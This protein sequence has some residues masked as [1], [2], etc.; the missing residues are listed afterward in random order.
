MVMTVA[1]LAHSELYSAVARTASG[2]DSLE[3]DR[4]PHLENSPGAVV[5]SR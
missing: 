1:L 4:K 5:V 2:T 3:T